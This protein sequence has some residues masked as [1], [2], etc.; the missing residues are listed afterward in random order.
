MLRYMDEYSSK[1]KAAMLRKLICLIL[2]CLLCLPAVAE[3]EAPSRLY[4][5]TSAEEAPK[6]I[7]DDIAG[8]FGTN[9]TYIDGY[10]T[11]RFGRWAHGQVI[12]QDQ[13]DYILCGLTYT[14]S[15]WKID[16]SRTALRQGAL[17]AFLPESVEYEYD[18]YEISQFDGC[19]NFD[20][21]YGDITYRWFAGSDGWRLGAVINAAENL[22]LSVSDRSITRYFADSQTRFTPQA[23][24]VFNVYS[25]L[26]NDFDISL[27]P[28]AWKEAKALS[29]A[30]EHGDNTQGI[31]VYDPWDNDDYEGDPAGV[32]FIKVYDTPSRSGKVIAHLFENVQAEILDRNDYSA[33]NIVNDWCQIRIHDFIGWIE[34]INLLIGSE[35][36]AAFL[37]S[38]EYAAVYGTDV[39]DVQPVYASANSTSPSGYI[40]C[41]S[42]IYVQLIT[43]E[44]RYLIRTQDDAPAWMDSSSVCMTDNY[45]EAYIYSSDPS[46]R[47]NLR[48]GPGS[49]YESIGK[50]YSGARVVFMH[51]LPC[52]KGWRRVL[53]EGVSGYV[54][55]EFLDMYADYY[56]EEWLPPLGKVQGVNSKGLN[57]RAAPDKNA[58]VIAAYPVGTS[59]EIL[60][61]HD[62]IWAH[63]RLQDGNSGYMMLQ[64]LGGEPKQAAENSFQLT[65]DITTTDGY[66]DPLCEMKR[67]T[68]I[69][70][71]ERPVK[72]QKRSI[73]IRTDDAY[74]Y[75][76]LDCASFW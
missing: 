2:V 67:G 7:A 61:I 19:D 42:L 16:H 8:L 26:L 43:A 11:M 22:E 53:I 70:I 54:N 55:T 18:D 25:P 10:A 14:D 62:S 52:E 44:D 59:V 45:Y 60:G 34:R 69:R 46:R 35:R 37:T 39:Q 65:C 23:S 31:T 12:L 50:Y 47:L 76:P 49:Q 51:Q 29:D 40:N 57:L 58:D 72:D 63:V 17:P 71:S 4:H 38:G 74:G 36:A 73:W 33:N 28:T 5:F 32:P 6:E 48:T 30:S 15:G 68:R 20:L 41:N 3:E 75:I 64:Y 1:E 13:D 27:F 56:G 21:V 66:G 9:V 24:S